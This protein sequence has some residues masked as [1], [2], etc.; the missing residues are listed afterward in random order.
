MII[1]LEMENFA[2]FDR[3]RVSFGSGYNVMTGESG[4]GKSL[5]LEG[6]VT[7][8]GVRVTADRIGQFAD[9]MRLRVSLSLAEDDDLWDDL[10]PFGIEAD[11]VLI[12]ERQVS[13]DNRSSYRIQGQIVPA[14]LVRKIGDQVVNYV[15][16]HQLLKVANAQYIR[17]WLDRYG[18]LTELRSQ[19]EQHYDAYQA[20]NAEVARLQSVAEDL[21]QLPLKRSTYEELRAL[22]L[23]VGEDERI[24]RELGQLRAGRQLLQTS[25]A[26]YDILDGDGAT[27]VLWNVAEAL[28]LIETLIT[29]DKDLQGLLDS[30]HSAEE[31]LQ[32]VRMDISRWRENLDL[33]PARLEVLEE[34]A[35][36]IMRAKRRFGPEIRD[37]LAYAESLREEIAALE[38]LEWELSRAKE[39]RERSYEELIIIADQLSMGRRR[40]AE[41]AGLDVSATVQNMEMPGARVV[42]DI[43]SAPIASHGQD[44]VEIL[45]TAN[46]GH[47]L[48]SLSKVASGGELARVAL[49]L[50]VSG[51]TDGES[52]YIFDEVDQGLSG[53]SADTV[54]RL[55]EQLGK[56]TQVI[57]VSHQPVVAARA[58]FHAVVGKTVRDGHSVA[59]VA[60]LQGRARLIEIA[61][62]LS[63]TSDEVALQHAEV[64]LRH[65]HDGA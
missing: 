37:I 55:L 10:L 58:A 42:F 33:D 12:L 28:R 53:A 41:R 11:E 39:K 23:E 14:Q 30:M 32:D 3:C 57:A 43:E 44:H 27:G 54:G 59:E 61:R 34:R 64:L 18:E 45:F 49:A 51:P 40:M 19:V 47:E 7:A 52:F 15:G 21:P 56:K 31:L 2:L 17:E 26:V 65:K 13:R 48:K 9:S 5:A 16:Q 38:N 6:V 4:A 36:H 62:M 29:Y 35:D 8:F 46:Q 25:G 1:E 24:Q 63:G 50:A 20:L 22:H 60:P